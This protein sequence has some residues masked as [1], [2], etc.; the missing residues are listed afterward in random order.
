MAQVTPGMKKYGFA[1]RAQ[2]VWQRVTEGMQLSELWSQ[3]RTDAQSSYRLYSKEVD[4]TRAAGMPQTKHFF[5]VVAQYFW[6]IVEKLSPARRVLLL[7]ALAL[8][9]LPG[10]EWEWTTRAGTAKV[11]GL[12]FH[13]YG[14]LL[15]FALL[16]LEVGDRVVMKRD[17]Q[18]AKEIQAW[19]LPA[20][21]PEIPGLEIAFTTRPANTVAGDYYDVFARPCSSPGGG[22]FL[23]AI[24]DVAGKSVPAAMLMATFQASL[25]TL[26][27][28][29]GSLTELVSRMNQYACSNSQNGRRFTTAFIAEFDPATRRLV[30][31]NAGHNDPIVRRQSG[32]IERLGTGGVPLGIM[33]DAAY[34]AGEVTMQPGDWLV[35]F[36]DGVVEAENSA[37]QEYGEQ[38]F[39]MML[40]SGT[41]LTPAMLLQSVMLDL[42]RFVGNT[43]QHDDITCMLLRAS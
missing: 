5:H 17:L 1:E 11:F 39:L 38:R 41:M 30:Y 15:L 33:S 20:N 4:S 37:Q 7:V 18:I 8:V 2:S 43:P 24:A 10:G 13:F 23:I 25:K 31:I 3:F 27:A 12:D 32:L 28:T 21:P 29:P 16:I 26:S 35:A 19:L 22:T 36:T 40:H 42:D 14:G 34:E 6:A 9:I